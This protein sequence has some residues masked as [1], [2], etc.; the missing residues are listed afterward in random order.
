MKVD[1]QPFD[2]EILGSLLEKAGS[3]AGAYLEEIGKTNLIDL[4]NDEWMCFVYEV[5]DGFHDAAW[6]DCSLYL[7]GKM[8]GPITSDEIP[9]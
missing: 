3:K 1:N 7:T 9:F 8:V 2:N 5:V 4:T 6:R